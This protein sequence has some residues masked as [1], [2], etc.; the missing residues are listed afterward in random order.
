MSTPSARLRA[1]S[2]PVTRSMQGSARSLA[3]PRYRATS[4]SAVLDIQLE[5]SASAK[6]I[7]ARFVCGAPRSC[8]SGGERVVQQ[9][10]VDSMVGSVVG[11]R[12]VAHDAASWSRQWNVMPEVSTSRLS[13]CWQQSVSRVSRGGTGH[14]RLSPLQRGVPSLRDR[15]GDNTG[16]GAV[17]G[18]AL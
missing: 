1:S 14:R 2:V 7:D 12:C 8:G 9:H 5:H 15:G 11:S 17:K 4:A 13:W 6:G 16:R 18:G 10:P 3:A